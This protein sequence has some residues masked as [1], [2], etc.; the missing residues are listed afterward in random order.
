[1]FIAT[2]DSF[3]YEQS[4]AEWMA[5]SLPSVLAYQWRLADNTR[6]ATTDTL[7]P[8]FWVSVENTRPQF[9]DKIVQID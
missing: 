7:Q 4:A 1:M 6:L 5:S 8:H 9:C 2:S 3:A